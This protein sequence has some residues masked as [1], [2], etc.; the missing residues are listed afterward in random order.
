MKSDQE[1]IKMC[2]A[3]VSWAS[4]KPKFNDSVFQGIL[5]FYHNAHNYSN[6]PAITD[7]QKYTIEKVIRSFRVIY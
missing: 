5:D 6:H 7:R 2:K 4:S 3:I 1:Y